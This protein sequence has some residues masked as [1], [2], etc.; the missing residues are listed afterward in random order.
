MESSMCREDG[1]WSPLPF[2]CVPEC[3][4][5]IGNG[6]TLV[7]DGKPVNS[8]VE[9]PWHVAIYD[10]RYKG[11]IT[12]IC[13]GTL[14]TT[15][16][17]V[18]AAHCFVTSS[19]DAVLR[20]ASEFAAAVGK[21]NRNWSVREN[22]AQ[23]RNVLQIHIHGYG[24]P[25]LNHVKDIT[26]VEMDSP[27][28]LTA[29][30]LPAC[31]DWGHEER[32][33]REGDMGSVLGWG[34]LRNEPISNTLQSTMLP[35]VPKER[36]LRTIPAKL[37][38]YVMS[39]DR[40]C[41]GVVNGTT[42]AHGDS[43]G[44]LVFQNRERRWFLHGVVSVGM[45]EQRTFAAFTNVSSFVRWMADKIQDEEIRAAAAIHH[46]PLE[47]PMEYTASDVEEEQ[48]VA[49]YR[50]DV[51]LN[52]FHMHW[53]YFYFKYLKP[54]EMLKMHRRGE[55]LFYM[56]GQ[57]IARHNVE[58]LAHHLPRSRRLVLREPIKEGY[59]PKLDTLVASRVWPGRPPNTKLQNMNRDGMKID[60]EDMERWT[61]RIYDAI[62]VGA[63]VN[64]S[65]GIIPLTEEDGA[66]M[67]ANT[68]ESNSLSPNDQLYGELTNMGHI[69]ISL[70]HDPE[71]RYLESF[72]VMGDAAVSLRDPVFY[73]WHTYILDIMRKYKDTMPSYSRRE[74]EFPG[75][76]VR[77]VD[78]FTEGSN[79]PNLLGTYWEANDLEL[80]RGLDF[81]P[82]PPV[83]ARL[84]FLQHHPFHYSILVENK[85]ITPQEG[86]VR[87]FLAPKFDEHGRSMVFND[88]RHF[89]IEMDKFVTRLQP[90]M[91]VIRRKSFDSSLTI[92]FERTF[93]NLN[94]NRP[95]H[96]GKRRDEF[97]FCGCGLPHNLLL[98][99]GDTEG[100][101]YNLFVMVTDYALDKEEQELH[102]SCNKAHSI[103]GVM[104]G[105]YPDKRPMGFPFDRQPASHV[106][107]LRSFL[108]PNMFVQDVTIRFKDTVVLASHNASIFDKNIIK[109]P[110]PLG[111]SA[112][113]IQ[114]FLP[115]ERPQQYQLPIII[116]A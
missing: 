59:Y 73:R 98:P 95:A 76:A 42:V 12:Q 58:R 50:E 78:V 74:L 60:L 11:G 110:T 43:G 36:C 114:S 101:T 80:S 4:R 18:S 16:F 27:V 84:T 32:R 70:A 106:R 61:A 57:I 94:A 86:Y 90:G 13:G 65:G 68:I 69:I 64:S 92:P 35:Y 107:S 111:A 82:R 93:R 88:Q 83:Y 85:G 102:G 54:K 7:V 116:R 108:T 40:F 52:L 96:T 77:G 9:F 46:T 79:K 89:M 25:R 53:H 99:K 39:N 55:L 19:T 71:N 47:I 45:P 44:G 29:A 48:R 20:P 37:V 22:Y 5:L 31:V 10:R 113:R 91:N 66:E 38:P 109:L 3:G 17:F 41:A 15:K 112:D 62:A 63:L 2:T 105:K 30:T 23:T 51:G 49:Y 14:I 81:A 26:L 103:C 67:L 72:G 21:L 28:Q 24:G 100:L 56:H 75:V 1:N 6:E 87:I 104:N 115:K 8:P 97:T 34:N 33:L